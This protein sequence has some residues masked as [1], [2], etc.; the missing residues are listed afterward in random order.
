M[1]NSSTFRLNI[2]EIISEF[3]GVFMVVFMTCLVEINR[4][5]PLMT[6][7]TLF[8]TYTL[9]NYAGQ[10]FSKCHLNPAVSLSYW[11]F[12]DLTLVKLILYVGSQIGASFC[13]GFLLLFFR[14]FSKDTLGQ[15]SL[16]KFPN[17]NETIINQFQGRE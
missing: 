3:I 15:P 16:G 13:A 11:L 10:R 12:G 5:D 4:R 9:M 7:F 2:E 8:M 17:S 14:G 1:I 6:G